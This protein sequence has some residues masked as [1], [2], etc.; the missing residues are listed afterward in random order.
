MPGRPLPE[1]DV[2]GRPPPGRAIPV[3]PDDD[4][5]ADPRVVEVIAAHRAGRAGRAEVL[6]ALASGRLLVPVVAVL[7]EAG[8]LDVA[9]DQTSGYRIDKASHMASVST[10]GHDGRRGQLA[11]TCL[12]S[13]RRWDPAARPVPVATRAAAEAALADGADALVVDLAGPVLL[14]LD[15]P[16]LRALAAG[17]QPLDDESGAV[18]WAVPVAVPQPD[19]DVGPAGPRSRWPGSRWP[20]SRWPGSRWPRL[21]RLGG[22]WF[23]GRWFRRVRR[24]RGDGGAPA[25]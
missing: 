8:P 1:R 4:G 20:G 6:E 22:R 15:R 3:P 23:G 17:W 18:R 2:P 11:F 16:T 12:S 7:D 24:T 25:R 21:P 5:S 19:G 14:E 9:G 10:T 13:L